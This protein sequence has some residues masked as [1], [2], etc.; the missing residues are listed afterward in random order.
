MDCRTL[1]QLQDAALQ[2]GTKTLLSSGHLAQNVRVSHLSSTHALLRAWGKWGAMENIGYPRMSPMFG[3]RALKTPLFAVG[4]IPADV[5]DI[6]NATR[7]VEPDERQLVIHRY[8]WHMTLSEIGKRIG[9]TKWSARRK[10]EAAEYAVHVAYCNLGTKSVFKDRVE[11]L[12]L[13]GA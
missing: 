7:V 5:M 2:R 12:S 10:I 9:C 4:Y 3:E 11:K 8:Q 13:Q 1:P 6:E